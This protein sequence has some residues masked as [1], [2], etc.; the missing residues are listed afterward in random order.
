MSKELKK[1][2]WKQGMSTMCQ[3]TENT[4]KEIEVIKIN[5]MKLCIGKCSNKMIYSPEWLNTGRRKYQ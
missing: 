4:M 3:K 2:V 5:H 1:S